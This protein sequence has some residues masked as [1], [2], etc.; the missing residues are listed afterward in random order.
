MEIKERVLYAPGANETELLRSLAKRGIKTFGLRVMGSKDLAVLALERNGISLDRTLVSDTTAGLMVY[1]ILKSEKYFETV[2]LVDSLNFI[3]S[4]NSLRM[5]IPDEN[6]LKL[7]KN[8]A[9]AVKNAAILAVLDKY[10]AFLKENSY[11]DTCSLL[12]SVIDKKISL[13]IEVVTLKEFPLKPLEKE[14][15]KSLK[16]YEENPLK[17]ELSSPYKIEQFNSF[18][19]E[20]SE[21][22]F[23]L[24]FIMKNGLKFDQCVVAA[25]SS[26]YRR[27]F[28]DVA[29]ENQ[30]PVTYG[31]KHSIAGT[32]A[33][34]VLSLVIEWVND[35]YFVDRF[36]EIF[37]PNYVDVDRVAM[38]LDIDK[39]YLGNILKK[40]GDLRLSFDAKENAEKIERYQKA[41]NDGYLDAQTE[42]NTLYCIERM[43]DILSHGI[44][45]LLDFV[46]I[47]NEAEDA[48]AIEQISSFVN[49]GV[50]FGLDLK[51]L[52]NEA[53][54]LGI[55]GGVSSESNLYVTSISKAKS[56][57]RK[58]LFVVGMSSELYPGKPSEDYI[59]LDSDYELLG[60]NGKKSHQGIEE[61]KQELESLLSINGC[62]KIYVSYPYYS[63][64]DLKLKNASSMIF[65]IFNT[66]NG[67][68]K[69]VEDLAGVIKKH[70]YFE[71]NL[72][73]AKE[74][75]LAYANGTTLLQSEQNVPEDKEVSIYDRRKKY[76]SA[77]D[78]DAYFRCPYKFYLER[79]IGMKDEFD[80][81][82]TG[83]IGS[84]DLGTLIHDALSKLDKNVTSKE[85]FK[86][87]LKSQF[88]NVYLV[89][90]SVLSKKM[91]AE[92]LKD[93]L[94]FGE[95]AYDLASTNEPFKVEEDIYEIHTPS[96]LGIHG[97]PDRSE[98]ILNKVKVIDY[99]VKNHI[100]HD[101]SKYST[102][103]QIL[104]YAY[105]L[106]K[107]FKT[108]ICGCEYRYLKQGR[109]VPVDD[110]DVAFKYYDERLLEL[111]HSLE[112]GSFEPNPDAKKEGFC[113]YCK[114]KDICKACIS[115]EGDEE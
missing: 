85:E 100:D 88:E 8:G 96:E 56:V 43:A 75:G 30:I 61:K 93:L 65:E 84:S 74:I 90:H 83:V 53:T 46:L 60:F 12:K 105:I 47:K 67:G 55:S 64:E 101:G 107:K 44:D 57:N 11:Y 31:F 110:L 14:L 59:V 82:S 5:E 54:S 41:I 40:C 28:E 51:Q 10:N 109:N 29:V 111:K 7:L 42:Q 98:K 106:K 1:Q 66:T 104:T 18:Y 81:D 13:E 102:C 48:R 50:E 4:I 108:D 115:E 86:A 99:K 78:I 97:F 33:G 22:E 92:A 113:T 58:Y 114:H 26:K 38:A 20:K 25:T 24:N 21:A 39:D 69:S 34:N 73:P 35:F 91:A 103:G 71:S 27:I 112:T 52:L 95:N 62:N 80:N 9:F 68:D 70:P 17:I 45:G 77:T 37:N 23:V 2:Q 3:K 49:Q 94:D 89:T 79:I 36:V 6:K 76:Y 16:G 32:N 19:S 72:S 87:E 15:L 63:T